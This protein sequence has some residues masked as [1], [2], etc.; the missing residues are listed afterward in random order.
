LLRR[1]GAER[2]LKYFSNECNVLG[3]ILLSRHDLFVGR[4]MLTHVTTNL[5]A[6]DMEAAYGDRIRSRLQQQFNLFTFSS[7]KRQ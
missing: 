5:D 1:T 6:D 3:E 2:N 7:D 4:G